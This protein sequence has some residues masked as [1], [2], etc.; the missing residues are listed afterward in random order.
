MSDFTTTTTMD[1]T[2]SAI[3]TAPVGFISA[4]N[5]LEMSQKAKNKKETDVNVDTYKVV[6]EFIIN[7][8]LKDMPR[9]LKTMKKSAELG[10]DK[11]VIH[12]FSFVP[13]VEGEEVPTHDK[14]GKQIMYIINDRKYF[15]YTAITKG[16]KLFFKELSER[17]G[18][19]YWC[20]F[21]KNVKDSTINI[22]VSWGPQ[23]EPRVYVKKTYVKKEASPVVEDAPVEE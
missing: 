5:L 4:A 17:F 7:E 6:R 21:Y 14:N 23:P 20:D 12:K 13:H 3:A 19:G 2:T 18:E 9:L 10:F 15:L 8:L 11:T 16:G 22:F 1:V